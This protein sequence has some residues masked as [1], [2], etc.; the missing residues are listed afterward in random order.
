M[1]EIIKSHRDLDIWMR[2]RNLVKDVYV[3]TN[4][5]PRSEDS[6]LKLQMRRAAIS[7]LKEEQIPGTPHT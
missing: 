4:G 2:A 1:N 3:L 5:F 6:V 7:A